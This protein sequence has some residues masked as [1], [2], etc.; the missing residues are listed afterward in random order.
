MPRKTHKVVTLPVVESEVKH[1]I[2]AA[3][4]PVFIGDAQVDYLCGACETPLC[5]GM[6]EGDLAG[7]AFTCGCGA[8]NVVPW[9]ADGARPFAPAMAAAH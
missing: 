1:A 8:C 6:R 3:G 2:R 4:E 7:L 5:I 9:P